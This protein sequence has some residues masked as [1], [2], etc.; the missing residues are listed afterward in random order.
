MVR[1]SIVTQLM[2]YAYD[3]YNY[4]QLLLHLFNKYTITPVDYP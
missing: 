1:Y 4:S 2:Q 3:I